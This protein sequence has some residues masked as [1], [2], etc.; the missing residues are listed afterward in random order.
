MDTTD[1][2]VRSSVMAPLVNWCFVMIRVLNVKHYFLCDVC[3]RDAIGDPCGMLCFGT[4]EAAAL[5]V[6]RIPT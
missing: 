4:V 3:N 1:F 2:L 6:L 5:L